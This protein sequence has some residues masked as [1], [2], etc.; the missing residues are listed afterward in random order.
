MGNL[1]LFSL[2]CTTFNQSGYYNVCQ[3]D[4]LENSLCIYVSWNNL[5]RIIKTC[6]TPYMKLGP[7]LIWT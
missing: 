7:K 3:L 5:N 4:E 2:F 6:A 1:D